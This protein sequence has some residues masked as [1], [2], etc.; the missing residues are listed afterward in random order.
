MR[1]DDKIGCQL[2]VNAMHRNAVPGTAVNTRTIQKV[3]TEDWLFF[4]FHPDGSTHG[5]ITDED[6]HASVWCFFGTCA[7]LSYVIVTGS[8]MYSTL[9]LDTRRKGGK[10]RVLVCSSL[11]R[12]LWCWAAVV[13]SVC[14]CCR[15]R[16]GTE[17]DGMGWDRR[18]HNCPG[19]CTRWRT[20]VLVVSANESRLASGCT[21]E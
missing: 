10:G 4:F 14:I 2:F 21:A 6:I 12:I 8:Y 18:T 15:E 5:I 13:P 3:F 11:F 9:R 17:R 16:G 20:P 1:D 7:H 19:S